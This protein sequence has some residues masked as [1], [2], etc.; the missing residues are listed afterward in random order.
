VACFV[1]AQR[2]PGAT[3]RYIQ[4]PA[5]LLRNERQ[6]RP[7]ATSDGLFRCCAT[8]AKCDL[9]LQP[10]L[11]FAGT[12]VGSDLRVFSFVR[13]LLRRFAPR[14]D[15]WGSAFIACGF[16]RRLLRRLRLLAM[17]AWG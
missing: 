5:S 3:W 9:A 8:N 15:R 17:T 7:G 14:N 6:V 13:R 4:R 1:A 2:T 12:A 10:Q 11:E 16:G